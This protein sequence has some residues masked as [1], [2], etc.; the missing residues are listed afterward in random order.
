MTAGLDDVTLAGSR[1]GI[2][3]EVSGRELAAERFERGA[4]V[5]RYLVLSRV[6]AGAMGVVF[7]AYD[8]E[9]DRKVALKLLSPRGTDLGRARERLQREARALAKLDHPN[10]VAVYDVGVHDEQ[11]FVTMEFVQGQTLGQW[12]A[13][14][15]FPEGTATTSH[16]SRVAAPSVRARP[17]REVLDVF[18]SAG[19]G[20]AVAHE[21]GLIHR[22]F[23]PDNVMLGDDGR[24]R[25]MDF[26]VALAGDREGDD[27]VDPDE[28]VDSLT[29]AGA[30]VGTPAY[31]SPE[32]FGFGSVDARSDQFGFCVAL[33]EAVYGQ[34]PF[35]GETIGELVY[36]L[37]QGRVLDPPRAT[38]V[39]SWVRRVV[40]KG[41][42][43]DPEDRF[44]TMR[45]LLDELSNDP[46]ARR[47]RWLGRIGLGVV[48]P[49][50][51]WGLVAMSGTVADHEATIE[52]QQ[53]Q[54]EVRNA[55]LEE[56]LAAQVRLG[57][58]ERG[59]R[60][61][62]LVD[63]DEEGEALLLGIQAMGAYQGAWDQAPDEAV[64]ALE[65]ALARDPA[66][67][68]AA[69]VLEGSETGVERGVFSPDGSMVA[70]VDHE[71]RVELWDPDRGQLRA[72]LDD[73]GVLLD[74][75]VFSPDGSRLAAAGMEGR[76]M[77]WDLESG[78]RTAAY[79]GHEGRIIALAFTPDGRGLATA[80]YDPYVRVWDVRTGECR[81]ELAGDDE[82]VVRTLAFTP[83]GTRL[84]TGG[85]DGAARVWDA[86][87]GET[88]AVLR[89]N[90]AT[91]H[92]LAISPDGTRVATGHGDGRARIWSLGEAEPVATQQGHHTV[93]SGVVFS[94]DG[95]RLIAVSWDGTGRIHDARTGALLHTLDDGHSF[96]IVSVD[97]APDGTRIATSSFDGGVAIWDARRGD[98]RMRLVGHRADVWNVA[99]S[100]DG[101]RLVTASNDGSARVWDVADDG[102]RVL[103]GPGAPGRW[104]A[105][106]SDH[107]RLITL[108]LDHRIRVWDAE[109]G[110][111]LRTLATS[112]GGPWAAMAYWPGRE[113]VARATRDGLQVW[114]VETGAQRDRAWPDE[115]GG[116]GNITDLRYSPGGTLFLLQT[117]DPLRTAV[118][119][120]RT[121]ELR[122]DLQHETNHRRAAFSSEDDRLAVVDR[123]SVV[124][125][126][127]PRDGSSAGELE[128]PGD[129]VELVAYSSDGARWLTASQEAGVVVWDARRLVRL[130]SLP[131]S[132]WVSTM[133]VSPDG[134]EL[135]ATRK[136]QGQARVWELH[137][138]E[139]RLQLDSDLLAPRLDRV[140]Y[141]ADGSRLLTLGSGVLRVFDRRTGELLAR[142]DGR[143]NSFRPVWLSPDGERLT[144]YRAD[145]RLEIHD[146][147]TGESS[148]PERVGLER[149][150]GSIVWPIPRQELVTIACA[151]LRVFEPTYLRAREICEPLLDGSA[152]G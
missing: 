19:R 3:D 108:G 41:L 75:L 91:I 12:M 84:V 149:P 129:I 148:S 124:R 111:R 48:L 95:D 106:S 58:I 64:E 47:R 99:F 122:V 128:L 35:S 133:V 139:R 53:H 13:A 44:P 34:R 138:G 42:A 51:V 117:R 16:S 115:L 73:V 147:T 31:M 105:Y 18:I 1:S 30:L 94:P 10:V 43:I 104:F 89:G 8:P 121:L 20:L 113:E 116:G 60:A 17:W 52:Q 146:L 82:G 87:T 37:H 127:D 46:A 142:I 112:G 150:D 36:A 72:T 137:T 56:Q 4:A 59:V 49:A 135:A 70:T 45:A 29:R 11:L 24:V 126:W 136:I 144:S 2:G 100:P 131:G 39:P 6:G 21:A 77:V 14:A 27:E 97:I 28:P 143:R 110:Q 132:R 151:R 86:A 68:V 33:Y 88:L 54:L 98:F 140:E 62:A 9:L 107:T 76:V 50:S 114:D 15:P 85:D 67:S 63:T 130:S 32:Q 102:V 25:V 145:H 96:G 23:K 103:D 7:A 93:V 118:F 79:V 69:H 90:E 38:R 22:D 83:D 78:E 125:L 109:T 80:G 74:R 119:D 101:R 81:L 57:A 134:T 123:T 40:V 66:T 55:K 65:H 120:A 26:G 141:S 92:A 71:G 5:G 61:K 152:G